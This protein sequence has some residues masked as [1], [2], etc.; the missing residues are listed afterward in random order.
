[1]NSTSTISNNKTHLVNNIEIKINLVKPDKQSQALAQ[2]DA[3]DLAN[4][5]DKEHK[6]ATTG[7][8]NEKTD[9]KKD[10]TDLKSQKNTTASQN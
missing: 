10:Q 2:I 1:M 9:L 8:K 4:K 5:T 7:A 3:K 6:N